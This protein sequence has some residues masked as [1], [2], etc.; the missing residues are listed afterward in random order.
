MLNVLKLKVY[1]NEILINMHAKEG[2]GEINY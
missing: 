2:K 1:L